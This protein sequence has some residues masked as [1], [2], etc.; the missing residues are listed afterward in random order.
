MN[1]SNHRSTSTSKRT[2]A[3]AAGACALAVVAGVGAGPSTAVGSNATVWTHVASACTPDEGSTGRYDGYVSS[4]R[5]APGA[6]GQIVTRCNVVDLPE[7]GSG[8]F[9]VLQVVYKDGDGRGTGEQVL[10][11]LIEAQ[12]DGHTRT[13]ASFNSNNFSGSAA[14]QRRFAWVTG[15]FNFDQNAY[16]VHIKVTRSSTTTAPFANTVRLTRVV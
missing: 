14:V 9:P 3:T 7:F 5:H 8:E 16:F 13:M 1:R 15:P 11:E 10:V 2:I 4:F 6:T 12:D